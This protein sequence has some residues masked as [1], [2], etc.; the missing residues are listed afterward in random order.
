MTVRDILLVIVTSLSQLPRAIGSEVCRAA[1]VV[2]VGPWA[3]LADTVVL[4]LC[5]LICR[6]FMSEPCIAACAV[7]VASVAM[8]ALCYACWICRATLVTAVTTAVNSHVLNHTVPPIFNYTFQPNVEVLQYDD[9]VLSLVSAL[10][11]CLRIVVTVCLIL[12]IKLLQAVGVAFLT[13][14]RIA[15]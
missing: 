12:G 14:P 15:L 11:S 3:L 7:T 4:I 8:L 13:C 2:L 9:S 10:F 6:R 1:F 5:A